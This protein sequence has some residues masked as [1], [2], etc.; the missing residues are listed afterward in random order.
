MPEVRK[1]LE[2]V[3]ADASNAFIAKDMA[4]I[5]GL[6]A[7]DFTADDGKVK[8]SRQE[9][10]EGVRS[11]FE[12]MDVIS[13]DR[14]LISVKHQGELVLVVNEGDFVARKRDGS[15]VRLSMVNEDAWEKQN[16]K[17]MLKWSRALG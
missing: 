5:D 13:W 7:Q 9:F 6:T 3:Y 16:D 1:A 12:A 17:W 14:N 4:F 8:K 10:I 15:E 11:Q 2:Q